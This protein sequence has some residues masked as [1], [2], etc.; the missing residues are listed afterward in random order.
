MA[1]GPAMI[2]TGCAIGWVNIIDAVAPPGAK[3][4]MALTSAEGAAVW[5]AG[6]SPTIMSP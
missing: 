3:E 1:I 4:A 6:G 5:V 2:R